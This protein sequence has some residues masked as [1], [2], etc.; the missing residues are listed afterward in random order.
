MG[1]E[2][3][4][5]GQ[6]IPLVDDGRVFPVGTVDFLRPSP[7]Q[8]CTKGHCGVGEGVSFGVVNS[9]HR[10]LITL[11]ASSEVEVLDQS[12]AMVCRVVYFL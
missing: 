12:I 11:L 9:V 4:G 10:A 1:H 3:R 5:E 6:S 8:S 2:L 7:V